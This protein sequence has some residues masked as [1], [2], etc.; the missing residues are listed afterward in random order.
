MELAAKFFEAQ[1]QDRQGAKARGYL[2]GRA[3]G[4]QT[5]VKFR[6]GYAPADRFALKEHLGGKGVPVNDMIAAGLLVDG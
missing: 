1:L 5:Q 4:P 6:I 3:L 2:A